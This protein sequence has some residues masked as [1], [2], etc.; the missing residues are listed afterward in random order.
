MESVKI[1]IVEQKALRNGARNDLC[2]V[3]TFA[4]LFFYA[5]TLLS[6]SRFTITT[7]AVPL[8][9]YALTLLCHYPAFR[10]PLTLL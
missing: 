4:P 5:L 2:S 1:K 6:P 8:F 3:P 10:L 9:F 7:S